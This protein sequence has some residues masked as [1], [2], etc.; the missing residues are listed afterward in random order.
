[1]KRLSILLI[2]ILA[3]AGPR[4]AT[5][6]TFLE[7]VTGDE[8]LTPDSRSAALGRTISSGHQGAF[9]AANNPSALAHGRHQLLVSLG[10]GYQK[11]KETR[12]TP[13]YD[14]F[15]A[16]LVNSSYALNDKYQ[17]EG[18]VG[19]SGVLGR[20]GALARIGAGVTWGPVWDFNYDYTEE[21]RDNNPFTQPR[22][23]LIALNV[24]QSNGTI[25]AVTVG[26]GGLAL[27]KFSVGASFQWLYGD[28]NVLHRSTSYSG[29]DPDTATYTNV[30]SRELGGARGVFSAAASPNHHWDFS[31]TWKAQAQLKGTYEITGSP[32]DPSLTPE[33]VTS[34]RLERIAYLGGFSPELAGLGQLTVRYP[35][36][37]GLGIVYRPQARVRTTLRVEANWSEWS[38]YRNGLY[39]ELAM[40][41]TWDFRFG[42]EHIFYNDM[43]VRF[44]FAHRPSPRDDQV[45]NTSFT[46]GGGVPIGPLRADGAVEVMNRKYRFPDLFDDADFG[47]TTRNRDDLVEENTTFFYVTLSTELDPFG[48]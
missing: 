33:E 28:N 41:D 7:L 1:M 48:G 17:T 15:D 29:G 6:L 5:A 18:G 46:V 19:V 25:D 32:E 47:G 3:A 13:L 37:V 30:D 11:L 38:Q 8:A 12:S 45:V 10:G 16:F 4:D 35:H 43:P 40:D 31:L 42:V 26:L 39:E 34:L 21:V 20:E 14:S 9:T 23:K 22:D 27:E 2:P 24:V 44:G 36:Q